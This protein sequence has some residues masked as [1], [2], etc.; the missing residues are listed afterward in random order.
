MQALVAEHHAAV[1]RHWTPDAA[2]Y[3]GLGRTY[4]DGP[5]F[6]ARYDALHPALAEFLRDAIAAWAPRLP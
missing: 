4:V 6:R 3:A 5:R 1:A 2:S